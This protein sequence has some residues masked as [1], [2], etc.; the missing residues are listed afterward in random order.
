MLRI[1]FTLTNFLFSLPRKARNYTK[2]ALLQEMHRHKSTY[3]TIH[4]S[5][6]HESNKRHCR[7]QEILFYIF[8]PGFTPRAIFYRPIGAIIRNTN[9]HCSINFWFIAFSTEISNRTKG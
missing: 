5:K 1:N 9:M 7:E 8:I 4:A 3:V 6:F 2:V